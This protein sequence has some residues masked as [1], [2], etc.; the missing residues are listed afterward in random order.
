MRQRISQKNVFPVFD[1]ETEYKKLKD[2]FFDRSAFGKILPYGR[3]APCLSFND[4]LKTA[5][6]DWE[7]R[8]TFT[9]I[10]EMLMSLK[11]SDDDFSANPS[12][13]RLLDYIQFIINAASFLVSILKRRKFNVYFA[14]AE[15]IFNAIADNAHL[16]LSRLG[17]EMINT[18][19]ELWVV[20][21]D[22]VASCV[23]EQNEDIKE[24]I[25]EYLKID[26][27]GNLQRKGELLCTLAKKLEP[28]EGKFNGTEFKTL[29]SNTTELLNKIGA[30]HALNDK[31][32][33]EKKILRMDMAEQEKWFDYTFQLCLACMAVIPYI[34]IKSKIKLLKSEDT[35]MM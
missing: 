28:H 4:C 10:E 32:R 7:L 14:G 13:E 25:I 30:R 21:K 9:S 5:F 3:S 22:D 31:D 24:S 6:L 17:A 2:L 29:C 26:N 15:T 16:L 1:I 23:A 35:K 12:E 18:P 11:I 19:G 33:I 20:Y 34:D 8:G 27:R